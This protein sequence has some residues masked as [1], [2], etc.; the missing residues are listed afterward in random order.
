MVAVSEFQTP[1]ICTAFCGY[2]F[3]RPANLV[4]ESF[5]F[6]T[7]EVLLVGCQHS[8][9]VSFDR[10]LRGDLFLGLE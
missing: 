9:H 10:D 3:S 2:R 1:D 5:F 6:K 8:V 4:D 7:R